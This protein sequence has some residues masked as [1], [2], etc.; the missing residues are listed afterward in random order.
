[1]TLLEA[2][3][4]AKVDVPTPRGTVSLRVPPGTSSGTRLRI[5]GHGVARTGKSSGDLY[6]EIAVTVPKP[7]TEDEISQIREICQRHPSHPRTDL[8]W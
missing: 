8:R 6:A 2:V 3:E 4:G 1:M 5:K 7:L